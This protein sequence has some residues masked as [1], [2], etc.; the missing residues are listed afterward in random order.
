MSVIN[1]LA[2]SLGR[3][4]E[5]PNVELAKEIVASGSNKAITELVD[6][7]K[8]KD[9]NIQADCLK[10]LYETGYLKPELIASYAPE[11]I[12]LLDNKS[13]RIVWGA[14]IAIDTI[15]PENPKAV[16]GA[17]A[18]IIAKSDAGTV[19]TKDHAVDILV[20]LCGVKEYMNTCFPL[21]NEQILRSPVNQLPTYAEKAATIVNDKY[22]PVLLKTLEVRLED[23][24]Q[25]TKRKRLEKVIKKLK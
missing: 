25:D 2:T 22:K 16:F 17:L 21:L 24:S 20:K 5:V 3:R 6:N 4:D 23:V 9:K 12:A 1:K 7:L 19:I 8:N 15:T 11:F 10:A 18:K 14:M 13:N